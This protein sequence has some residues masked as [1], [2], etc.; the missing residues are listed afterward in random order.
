[1]KNFRN[2]EKYMSFTLIEL[3][4]VIAIIAILAGMLLPALNTA[5]DKARGSACTN[6]LK[7]LYT[8]FAMYSGD[9]NGFM[10]YGNYFNSDR[11]SWQ[12]WFFEAGYSKVPKNQTVEKNSIFG[13]PVNWRTKSNEVLGMDRSYGR[14]KWYAAGWKSPILDVANDS[15]AVIYVASKMKQEAPLLFD[16]VNRVN[17]VNYGAQITKL[18][19]VDAGTGG[20]TG[21]VAAKHGNRISLLTFSGSA[22]IVATADLPNY[23]LAYYGKENTS[24]ARDV[25]VYYVERGG[26]LKQ[27]K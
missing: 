5:R 23:F 21:N 22:S 18:S 17:N 19:P 26:A 10:P 6:N 1:M 24:A 15:K 13:C 3:L 9:Y 27:L 4:V 16:S 14:L 2:R 11:L 7:Q 20:S 12:E 8:Y 25:P